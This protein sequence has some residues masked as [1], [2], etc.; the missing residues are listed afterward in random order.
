MEITNLWYWRKK[1]KKTPF[2]IK[3][4]KRRKSRHFQKKK[5]LQLTGSPINSVIPSLFL[6]SLTRE[7]LLFYLVLGASG[8]IL[9]SSMA[10]T[11]RN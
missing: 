7:T 4:F 10:L 8:K 1:K 11:I 3:L 9:T 2:Q 5:K 6:I